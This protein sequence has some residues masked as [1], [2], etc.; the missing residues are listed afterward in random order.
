[1]R[2]GVGDFEFVGVLSSIDMAEF[3]HVERL[4]SQWFGFFE[5]G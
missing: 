4:L 5:T 1:M 2:V 3:Y